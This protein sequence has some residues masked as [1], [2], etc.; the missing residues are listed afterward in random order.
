MTHVPSLSRTRRSAATPRKAM[1]TTTRSKPELHA[2]SAAGL[3]FNFNYTWSH[4][5]TNQDSSGWGSHRAPRRPGAYD[6]DA[7]YGNSNFDVRHMFKGHVAIRPSVRKGRQFANTSKP[8]MQR[9]AAGPVRRFLR[10]RAVR[11]P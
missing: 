8:S 3:M 11:S 4:M 5:L 9:L 2:A 1:G 7:N 6:P 10:K